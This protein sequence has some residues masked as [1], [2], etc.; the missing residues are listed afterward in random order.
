MVASAC[1]GIHI[2]ASSKHI[3][4]GSSIVTINQRV[5]D[6]QAVLIMES[7]R[8][9][10]GVLVDDEENGD[11]GNAA[12]RRPFVSCG[13]CWKRLR[14][15]AVLPSKKYRS[16]IGTFNDFYFGKHVPKQLKFECYWNFVITSFL[17]Y[18]K[19]VLSSNSVV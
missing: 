8:P 2:I 15:A 11:V 10:N 14:D 7:V 13:T 18:S 1:L 9:V 6:I 19:L 5:I 4:G 12:V 17:Y 3:N 16:V